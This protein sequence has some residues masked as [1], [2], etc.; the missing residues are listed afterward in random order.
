MGI[1]P[2]SEG[3]ETSV[4]NGHQLCPKRDQKTAQAD[5]IGTTDMRRQLRTNKLFACNASRTIRLTG[6]SANFFDFSANLRKCFST[7]SST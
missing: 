5:G 6:P 2:T 4:P 1:E 7:V 3:W